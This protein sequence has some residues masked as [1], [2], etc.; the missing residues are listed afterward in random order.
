MRCED[1]TCL[2][3]IFLC[4]APHPPFFYNSHL[5]CNEESLMGRT[6]LEAYQHFLLLIKC[7]RT[8]YWSQFWFG[9]PWTDT[10]TIT[11]LFSPCFLSVTAS[12]A[13]IG[14]NHPAIFYY[15]IFF[16]GFLSVEKTQPLK[17]R[18]F[19]IP[20]EAEP[21]GG[22]CRSNCKWSDLY[23]CLSSATWGPQANVLT[24]VLQLDV[25]LFNS[26]HH[27]F[28][29]DRKCS[30]SLHDLTQQEHI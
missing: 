5:F 29:K 15:I 9:W 4:L 21:W 3:R 26:V 25:S 23:F 28:S 8:P 6:N 16:S 20:I 12:S 18:P 13:S 19:F 7:L 10:L 14:S 24:S 22:G 1:Y 11:S 2:Q 17:K 30:L 27:D